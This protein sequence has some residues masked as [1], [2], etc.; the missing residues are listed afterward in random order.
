MQAISID[1][2]S[3]Y[4][5]ANKTPILANISLSLDAGEVLTII[6]PNGAG[7]STLLKV[8]AG[9]IDHHA[10]NIKGNIRISNLSTQPLQ[11]ARQLAVLPQFSLLNFPYKVHQVVELARIPHNTGYQQDE[12]ICKQV[13]ELLDIGYLYNRLY[14]DLSGGE[15]QRVQ[16]ARVFAQ[17]W[18]QRDCNAQPRYLILDEPTTALDIGHQHQLMTAIRGL[19]KQKVTVVMVLHDVNMAMKYSDRALALQC[20]HS[21]GFGNVDTIA[22]IELMEKLFNTPVSILKNPSDDTPIIVTGA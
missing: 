6:G 3:V 12:I 2:L 19:A 1:N 7:K 11:R 4:L 10:N 15:K 9:D 20:G 17:I 21:M 16:L 8:L 22:N 18:R 14:T 13:L 5:G